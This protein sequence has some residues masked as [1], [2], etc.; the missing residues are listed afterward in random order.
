MQL[1]RSG[2]ASLAALYHYLTA[3]LLHL[4]RHTHPEVS[5]G[6]VT[7]LFSDL[8]TLALAM[9]REGAAQTS[10]DRVESTL[11]HFPR[12][13]L[14]SGLLQRNGALVQFPHLTF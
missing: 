6:Q 1:H 5:D 14:E 8:Q 2:G 13:Y 3:E 7:L 10:V 9:M 12:R 4:Y 11:G